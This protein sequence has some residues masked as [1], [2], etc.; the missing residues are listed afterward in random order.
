MSTKDSLQRFLFENAPI[1]GEL[2]RLNATWQEVLQRHTYPEPVRNLLGEMMAASAL[3]SAMLKFE[4]SLIMQIQGSG[5]LTLAVSECTSERNLR[6][7]A[8]W[9]DDLSGASLPELVGKGSL[10]I[11]IEPKQGRRY[12][13]IVDVGSGSLTKAIEDYM[14]RSQQLETR[15]WLAVD[16]TQASGL[17]LQKMPE[18]EDLHE[19]DL[20]EEDADAWNRVTVLADTV[21]QDELAT[22]PFDQLL[23]RLFYEEDVRLFEAEP[24]SFRCSCSKDRVHNTLRML[25]YEEIISLFEERPIISVNCEFCNH[26]YEFDRVDIEELFASDFKVEGSH[27]KH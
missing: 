22:L 5:P 19:R 25:G 2:V 1:R 15:M 7:I 10:A 11:T 8:N 6:A 16:E 20:L 3:L 24:V 21:H 18:S 9:H 27:T 13:G 23:R 26:L 17:L 12:Q 4:G 14:H